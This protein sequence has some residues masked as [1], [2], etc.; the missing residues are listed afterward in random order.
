MLNSE[1]YRKE[2]RETVVNYIIPFDSRTKAAPASTS[3]RDSGK[4]SS[5][6]GWAIGYESWLEKL[7]QGFA[8]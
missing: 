8:M 3:R 4:G 1:L 5:C 7:M 6:G 2:K